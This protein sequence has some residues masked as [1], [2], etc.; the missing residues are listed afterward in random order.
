MKADF[1]FVVWPYLAVG[2]LCAGIVFRLLLVRIAAVK[3]QPPESRATFSGSRLWRISLVLL[4]LGHLIGLAF[5]REVLLWNGNPIRLYLLESFAFAVGVLAFAGWGLLLWRHLKP[6]GRS[7]AAEIAD[8][9]FLALIFAAL[10]SG[11]LMAA[12]YRWGSFWGAMTLTP[13]VISLLREEPAPALVVQMPFLVRLHIFSSFAAV[14]LLPFTRLAPVVVLA[15]NRG[16]ELI[17][18]PVSVIG[19]AAEAWLTR[20]NPA[21]WIWPEED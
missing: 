20:H 16:I 8:T 10:L 18:R 13:Y 3:A 9:A 14:A 11:L 2:V 17:N 12:L 5:P 19:H 15:L 1:L 4:L 7:I 6:T 21:A